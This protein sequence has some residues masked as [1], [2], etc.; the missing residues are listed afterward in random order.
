MSIKDPSSGFRH[1]HIYISIDSDLII[2]FANMYE[3][4]KRI[5]S[6]NKDFLN[7]NLYAVKNNFN[8]CKVVFE[9]ILNGTIRPIITTTIFNEVSGS[10]YNKKGNYSVANNSMID[11]LTTFF[12][13]AKPN[14]L[15]S[16]F[17]QDKTQVLAKAY[18]MNYKSS[19]GNVMDAPLEFEYVAYHGTTSPSN[20]AIAMAEAS[21]MN[22]CLL[23]YNGK[24]LIWK[25]NWMNYESP[26]KE[27]VIGVLEINRQ[28]GYFSKKQTG[29][30][31][32][33]KP[34]HLKDFAY[35]ISKDAEAIHYFE[36]PEPDESKLVKLATMLNYEE[37]LDEVKT[38]HENII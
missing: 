1:E 9:N 17:R 4:Y 27:R 36:I 22:V 25:K 38:H 6:L 30:E 21:Y 29:E 13:T 19:N 5:H 35:H 28:K 15:L 7:D 3:Q 20:D 8:E 16:K 12:Y 2:C 37:F 10:I 34:L 32:I 33:P 14:A 11:F 18:C 24:D 31:L 26:K 23:T